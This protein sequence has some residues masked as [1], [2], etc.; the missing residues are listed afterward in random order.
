[1]TKFHCLAGL[2]LAIGLLIFSPHLAQACPACTEFA[3]SADVDDTDNFAA[4][5]NESIYVMLGV[6]FSALFIVGFMIY[7]GAK[8]NEAYREEMGQRAGSFALGASE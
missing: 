8:Q 1:M 4:A 7:R 2:L 5:M 6:P 3:S